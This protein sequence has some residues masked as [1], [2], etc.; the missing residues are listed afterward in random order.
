MLFDYDL[1]IQPDLEV[2]LWT[3]VTFCD[4]KIPEKRGKYY[5][6]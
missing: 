6:S 5:T 2:M 4:P 1:Q 3:L